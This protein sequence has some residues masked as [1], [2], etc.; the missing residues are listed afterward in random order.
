MW[1]GLGDIFNKFRKRELGL[2]P[3]DGIWATS[4]LYRLKVPYTYLWY[5]CESLPLNSANMRR[6]PTLL[7]KPDDWPDYIDISGFCSLS[8]GTNYTPPEEL[9]RFLKSGSSPVYIG[10][11]SIVVDDPQKLTKSVFDAIKETGERAIISKGWGNL[12]GGG[13]IDVPENVYLIDNCPHDW[14][15]QHVTCVVHH[16]GAGTT[17]TGL[18]LG[19]PTV[20]ISFFGD[21]LFWGSI[22]AR[23]GV[24]PKP[25]RYGD[26]TSGKLAAAIKKALEGSTLE[27]AHEIGEQ[28]RNEDGVENAVHSFHRHLDLSKLRCALVP[29]KPAAWQVKHSETKLSAVAAAVLVDAGCLNLENLIL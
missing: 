29:Y 3:L 20:V 16:G 2:R 17:A 26:L 11:G 12:G 19:R 21:Q 4:L 25:I 22:V 8:T 10:F 23:A 27:R 24:G 14:L 15:F 7:P 1:Q 28:M 9:D 5:L 18:S 13:A 6:S